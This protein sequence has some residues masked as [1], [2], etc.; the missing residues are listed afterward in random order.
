MDYEKLSKQDLIEEIQKLTSNYNKLNEHLNNLASLFDATTIGLYKTNTDGDILEVNTALIKMLGYSNLEDI[1]RF[2]IVKDELVNKKERENFIKTLE[3]NDIISGLET[4]WKKNDGTFINIR[5]S[6]RAIKNEIGEIICIEGTVENIDDKKQKE[7][8]LIESEKKYRTLIDLLPS[9]FVIHKDS[10]VVYINKSMFE[11]MKV[12][13]ESELIGRSI[14]EFI[15]PNYH[16]YVKDRIKNLILNDK[17]VDV[18]IELEII[19]NNEFLD[20]ESSSFAVK[21]NEEQYVITIIKN[22]TEQKRAKQEILKAKEKAE[23]LNLHREALLKAVP[24]IIVTVEKNGNIIEFYSNYKSFCKEPKP[25]DFI[26]KNIEEV[27]SKNLTSF[28][29]AN[30]DKVLES[31]QIESFTYSNKYLLNS[32]TLFFDTRLVYLNE[33]TV[34]LVIRDVTERMELLNDL[35]IAKQKA[36]ESERLKTAFLANMSHE[37]R[38]PMNAIIGFADLLKYNIDENEKHEYVNIIQNSCY[39]L[40]TVLDDIIEL[41]KIESGAMLKN[42]T[43][44]NLNELLDEVYTYWHNSVLR[45]PNVELIF[46]K[47]NSSN[48]SNLLCVSDKVK[49]KQVFTNLISNALKYTESGKVEFGYKEIN[50]SEIEFYVSD[51]GVGICQEN[52]EN[53]F[54]RF[55]QIDNKLTNKTKGAGIGL[56]IC[57]AYSE[58]LGG[59]ITVESVENEGTTF[60]FTF[61]KFTFA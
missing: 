56:S 18:S 33:T 8:I 23:K 39:Q 40:L 31:R 50:V 22:I 41:S 57:K 47:A 25:E 30:I 60:Y 53:I 5:E 38:T 48:T 2:N 29:K 13:D 46:N 52:I 7:Q 36:E 9:G 17:N 1:Q 58:L 26:N 20:V 3:K 27:F 10:K 19:A 43:S 37:V 21:M 4:V 44:F 14:Y 55:T 15:R 59:K 45:N 11:T 6:A 28:F 42:V 54:N 35:E 49:I 61:P 51:T 16:K 24:D 12:I 34:L 32:R